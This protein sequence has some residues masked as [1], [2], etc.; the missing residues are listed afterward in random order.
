MSVT[1]CLLLF[2]LCVSMHAC[3]SR[4]RHLRAVDK[5]LEK[6]LHFSFRVGVFTFSICC[7]HI[8][9]FFFTWSSGFVQNDHE[10]TGSDKISALS[11]VKSSPSKQHEVGRKGSIGGILS[12][13]N[14]LK[15][16]ETRTGQKIPK[17]KGITSA[18][19]QTDQSLESVSLHVPH[20]IK[21]SGKDPGWLNLDYS[22]PKTHPPS[23]NWSVIVLIELKKTPRSLFT[24]I[25]LRALK[26]MV[27]VL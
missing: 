15:Q 21:R 5:K 20:K 26:N 12:S 3:N 10:K 22:P 16:K 8:H 14:T 25:I 6:K 18:A 24:S 4:G 1:S 2:L 19:V 17:V 11:K 13:E 27:A 7:H 9:I 23:H